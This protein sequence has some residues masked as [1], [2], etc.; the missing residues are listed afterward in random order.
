MTRRRSLRKRGDFNA[1]LK[2]GRRYRCDG[3]TLTVAARPGGPGRIGLAVR[4][5]SAVQRNRIK[6]RFRAAFRAADPRGCD[7]VVRGDAGAESVDF[8]KLVDAF[9][10]AGESHG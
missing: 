5:P 8:Q 2:E 3:V 6:R 4:A 9:R 7:I 10:A 1:T